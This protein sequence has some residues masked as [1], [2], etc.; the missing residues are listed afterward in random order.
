MAGPLAPV[1]EYVLMG[2]LLNH[3]I[4][5][6]DLDVKTL[7]HTGQ[8]VWKAVQSL[9][10][11]FDKRGVVLAA[12]EVFGLDKS[13]VQDYLAAVEKHETKNAAAV[14]DLL[15]K[16][17]AL[18]GIANEVQNQ[19]GTGNLD[20]DKIAGQISLSSKEKAELVSV[21]D[22]LV[23]G[24]PEAPSGPDLRS[25]PRLSESVHGLHGL[26]LIT[27]LPGIGKSTLARQL[28]VDG[29]R[30][31]PALIYDFENPRN[32]ILFQLVENFGLEA[33][34]KIGKRMY[35]RESL[36]TLHKDLAKVPPPAI[37]L[38]DSIQRVPVKSDD[39]LQGLNSWI[40]RF[41]EIKQKGYSVILVSEINR[42]S[43]TGDPHLGCFKDSGR[44]EYAASFALFLQEAEGGFIRP[45]VIKNRHYKFKGQLGL[46]E[47]SDKWPFWFREVSLDVLG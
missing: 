26:W 41:E 22:D 10:A 12:V 29:M 19:L 40:N 33:A 7:S 32:D 18:I 27:G 30:E 17:A 23:E 47:R 1:T 16:R 42:A 25:M 31:L 2:A 44:L 24:A 8:R 45:H 21:T 43:Y 13:R 39:F 35:I 37:V 28:V 9:G 46:I 3:D 5:P 38:V 6:E 14:F 15:R 36:R 20:L 11:D 34:R 4:A